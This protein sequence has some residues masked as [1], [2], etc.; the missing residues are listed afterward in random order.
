MS[1][2]KRTFTS[3]NEFFL[4][5]LIETLFKGSTSVAK[6]LNWIMGSYQRKKHLTYA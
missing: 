3:I 2:S 4:N 6:R 5:L 1:V